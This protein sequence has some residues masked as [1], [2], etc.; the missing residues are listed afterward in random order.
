MILSSK[1]EKVICKLT[2]FGFVKPQCLYILK[3]FDFERVIDVANYFG[4]LVKNK[5]NKDY[6]QKYFYYLLNKFDFN[7]TWAEYRRYYNEK[8]NT[9]SLDL[10]KKKSYVLSGNKVGEDVKTSDKPKNIIEF[11]KNGT[12]SKSKNRS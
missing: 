2:A 8:K 10:P 5:P 7:K 9:A 11:I 3:N 6:N 1:R 12:K 4:W